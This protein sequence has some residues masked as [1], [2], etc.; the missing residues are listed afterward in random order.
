MNKEKMHNVMSY[1][2]GVQD[3]KKNCLN[4]ISRWALECLDKN[5]GDYYIE[6]EDIKRLNEVIINV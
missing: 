4:H 1:N 3:E 5:S 2:K 6:E